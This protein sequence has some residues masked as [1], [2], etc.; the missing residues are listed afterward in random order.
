MAAT[1]VLEVTEVKVLLAVNLIGGILRM[2]NQILK[3][4]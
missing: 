4:L 1:T 3:V 2:Q